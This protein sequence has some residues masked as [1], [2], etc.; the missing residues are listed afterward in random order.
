MEPSSPDLAGIV[1]RL[2]TLE[3]E[4]SALRKLLGV[5]EDSTFADRA[6]ENEPLSP[7]LSSLRVVDS[8]GATRARLAVTQHG[9][10]L[11]FLGPDE[12]PRAVIRETN[13]YGHLVVHG[14]HLE[15]RVDVRFSEEDHANVVLTTPAGVPCALVK[16]TDFGGTISV[17]NGDGEPLI[18]MSA[19]QTGCGELRIWKDGRENA[20]LILRATG[21]GGF[22][23]VSDADAPRATLCAQKGKGAL[24]ITGSDGEPR[25]AVTA[26]QD[27]GVVKVWN[28]SHSGGAD[29]MGR[30]EGGSVTVWSDGEKEV[31]ALQSSESGGEIRL[32]N[33]DG[34]L[35]AVFSTPGGEALLTLRCA[36]DE[37]A[38]V[39]GVQQK[40]GMIKLSTAGEDGHVILSGGAGFHGLALTGRNGHHAGT[41]ALH[42]DDPSI[43]AWLGLSGPD[44]QVIAALSPTPH[45]A[46]LTLSG[47]DGKH[48]LALGCDPAGGRVEVLNVAGASRAAIQ[49]N[50]DCGIV[51][52]RRHDT[53]A[54]QLAGIPIGGACIVCDEAG[55]IRSTLDFE[56]ISAFP[57]DGG[58]APA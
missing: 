25:V 21:E 19:N 56:G 6:L 14:R 15:S 44:S 27:S 5:P 45:G 33:R 4:N 39:L 17:V 23:V 40:S 55:R 22:V 2:E 58:G 30:G 20:E 46:S 38:A 54:A 3:A 51:T 1:R 42:P 13:G 31:A 10:S 47:R 57:G 36:G 32:F 7:V 9:C 26:F 48:R 24:M 28:A 34:D 12:E 11:S 35:R 16:A 50:E 8:Q 37:V 41:F 29:M 43:G 52:V 49:V 18:G 53:M